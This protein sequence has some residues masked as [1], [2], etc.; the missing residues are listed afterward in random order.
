MCPPARRQRRQIQLCLWKVFQV[1]EILVMSSGAISLVICDH[2]LEQ[3]RGYYQ[4][5]TQ[6]H[7]LIIS[8]FC[9]HIQW[10]LQ[11]C[12]CLVEYRALQLSV[13]P[14]TTES[15]RKMLNNFGNGI[16]GEVDGPELQYVFISGAL[17][18]ER[19][20]TASFV[21]VNSK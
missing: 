8:F 10:V 2:N 18:K 3:G 14:P 6:E 20:M 4:C 13:H 9:I 16:C 12:D 5:H 1:Q 15:R 21:K 11:K 7:L 17:H 19:L